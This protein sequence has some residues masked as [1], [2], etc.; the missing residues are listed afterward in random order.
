MLYLC[1]RSPWTAYDQPLSFFLHIVASQG[2]FV[3]AG[4]QL[5]TGRQLADVQLFQRMSGLLLQV[6]QTINHRSVIP[7]APP[8][9][10]ARLPDVRQTPTHAWPM[11]VQKPQARM[12]LLSIGSHS[13]SPWLV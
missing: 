7:Q 13:R 8:P 6:K 12:N 9:E 5:L 1:K 11:T 10:N 2:V 3:A 4:E